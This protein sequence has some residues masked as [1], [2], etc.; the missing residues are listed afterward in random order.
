MIE[1]GLEFSEGVSVG[2][3]RIGQVNNRYASN[4]K[5]LTGPLDHERV[6]ERRLT[7]VPY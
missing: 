1:T 4:N 7:C 5:W 2:R 6:G 3:K